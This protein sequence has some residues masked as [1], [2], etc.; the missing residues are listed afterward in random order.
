MPASKPASF[1]YEKGFFFVKLDFTDRFIAVQVKPLAKWDQ[2]KKVWIFPGT[3]DSYKYLVEE[4][5]ITPEPSVDTFLQEQEQVK[6]LHKVKKNNN[7]PQPGLININLWN[8]QKQ[9][10]HF[11][12]NL[13]SA[14]LFAQMGTGKTL[15]SLNLIYY[16]QPESVLIVCPKAVV[17]VWEKEFKKH[18]PTNGYK[19]E[20]VPLREKGTAKK[21]K[22]YSKF[23][24]MPCNKI[25]IINYESVWREPFGSYIL[26]HPPKMMIADESHKIKAPSSKVGV[27]FSKL[28][29]LVHKKYILTGTPTPQGAEDYFGQF[30]FLN[31]G[32]FGKYFNMFAS[33]YIRYGGFDNKEIIGYNNLDDLNQKV[34]SYSFRV[35]AEDVL[36]LPEVIEEELELE[37]LP[38]MKKYYIQLKEHKMAEYENG[39]V[40]LKNA[41]A[42]IT[43]LQQVVSGFVILD[44]TENMMR[45]K[46]HR[47]EKNEKLDLLMEMLSDI[48]KKNKVVIFCNFTAEIDI[49]KEALNKEKIKYCELSGKKHE[50]A[51][52]QEDEETQVIVVQYK[53]GGVGVD[54][55]MARY[56]FYFSPTYNLGDFEQSK[57]RIHRPG[58]KTIANYYYFVTKG[59]VEKRVYAKLRKKE[60]IVNMLDLLLEELKNKEEV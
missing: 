45:P 51:Q 4:H 57:A 58:Q 20:V 32:L 13:P 38:E 35:K 18:P 50:T 2:N 49:I 33:K 10:F 8:H 12:K 17:S 3:I 48:D 31:P 37:L 14:G 28:S 54:L 46:I 16:R 36:D 9:A 15:V 42:A 60:E 21:L 52:F 43:K 1:K 6:D 29:E 7:L 30:R 56:V 5:K 53:A 26:K 34:Y 24:S 23:M 11:M 39:E 27:M 40:T 19:F 41:A 25:F 47:F 55:S 44:K 22:T 59:T